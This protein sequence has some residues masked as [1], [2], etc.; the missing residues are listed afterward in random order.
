MSPQDKFNVIPYIDFI[1][2]CCCKFNM[3]YL[4]LHNIC[5]EGRCLE[6]LKYLTKETEY[7]ENYHNF[8]IF[9]FQGFLLDLTV[10]ISAQY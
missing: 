4:S 8:F 6:K 2:Q 5:L 1:M 7:K 10:F 9:F 3:Y